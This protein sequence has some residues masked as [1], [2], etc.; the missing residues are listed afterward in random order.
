MKSRHYRV[1]K[2]RTG[3][4]LKCYG[5]TTGI[6]RLDI[7]IAF[8]N[9]VSSDVKYAFRKGVPY[10]VSRYSDGTWPVLYTAREPETAIA[11]VSYHSRKEW[12]KI[13]SKN[14]VTY[15]QARK[16]M[17]ALKVDCGLQSVIAPVDA[18]TGADASTYGK[19]HEVARQALGDGYSSLCVP[20]ARRQ[21]GLCVPVFSAHIIE[22][23]TGV[24]TPFTLRWSVASDDLSHTANGES[25][26]ISLWQT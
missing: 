10:A 1:C 2:D 20:S 9:V 15:R 12:M 23:E 7:K 24:E 22:P 19:C 14:S 18:L 11:E 3:D 5:F 26:S 17:Y 4:E 16:L 21:N 25:Q 8:Q 13:R 6:L